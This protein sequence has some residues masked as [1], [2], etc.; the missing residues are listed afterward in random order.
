MDKCPKCNNQLKEKKRGHVTF[1]YCDTCFGHNRFDYINCC[2]NPNK[3]YVK[4]NIANGVRV[5]LQCKNCGKIDSKAQ[6]AKALN[7]HLDELEFSDIELDK[8]RTEKY[9]L[10]YRSLWSEFQALSKS[11]FLEHH[12]EYLNSSV[13]KT[14]RSLVLKRDSYLCQSCLQNQ[15]TQVHH[16]GYTYHMNEPLYTLISVCKRCHDI[17]TD[18][19]NGKKEYDS[20]HSD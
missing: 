16:R 20:I 7:I 5:R 11:N 6:N 4:H 13:W 18:M 3:V 14:K 2:H 12:S 9:N 1:L 10:D 17:I 19:D 15:A 8:K